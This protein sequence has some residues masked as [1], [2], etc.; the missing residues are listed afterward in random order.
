MA[1]KKQPAEMFTKYLEKYGD[2]KTLYSEILR[3]IITRLKLT[4]NI[5]RKF[6]F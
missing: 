2:E 6:L 5:Y 4:T 3:L 1:V